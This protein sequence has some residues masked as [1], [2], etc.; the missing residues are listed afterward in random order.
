MA[1]KRRAP[2]TKSAIVASD[3]GSSSAVAAPIL[4]GRDSSTGVGVTGTKKAASTGGPK[5]TASHAGN[6]SDLFPKGGDA[7]AAFCKS[8]GVN[9]NQYRPAEEWTTL[10]AEFAAQPIY[11]CRRGPEGGSH[12]ASPE[13]LG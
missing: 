8:K 2:A 4:R 13:R 1:R 9:T 5:I 10:L 3:S 6:K 11:G 12:Q 7:F